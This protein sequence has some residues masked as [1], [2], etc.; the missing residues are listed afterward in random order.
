MHCRPFRT[1]L[2]VL[3]LGLAVTLSAVAQRAPS[4]RASRTV[5]DVLQALR[6]TGAD[7]LYSSDLV[8]ADLAA[9]PPHGDATP[10]QQAREALAAHGLALRE[11]SPDR[12][13]VTRGNGP[14][15]TAAE[16]PA[17]GDP[18]LVEDAPLTSVSVYASR[19]AIEGRTVGEPRL[20]APTDLEMVPGSQ[21]DALRALRAVPGLATSV[22]ARP[23]IRGSL[24]EDALIRFDGVTLLDPFHLK[25]FQSLISAI[26][27]AAVDR[28]EIYSSGFPVRY[29]TRSGGVIDITPRSRSLGYENSVS[30]SLL[31]A[32][33]ASVGRSERWPLEWLA[34]ARRS[35][36]DLVLEPLGADVGRPEFVDT[37]GRLRWSPNDRSAWTI[38]WLLLDDRIQ[39]KAEQEQASASY[40]DEYLWLGYEH[41]WNE[42]WRSRTVLASTTADR[43]RSGMLER[44][45]VATGTLAERRAIERRQLDSD[46]HWQ[47]SERTAVDYGATIAT[48]RANYDYQRRN[49]FA[50]AA[51]R[52]FE[53]RAIENFAAGARAESTSYAAYASIGHRWSRIEAEAGLRFDADDYAPGESFSHVSPRL[54]LRFDLSH[55]W[56]A[57]ASL[58]EFTQAQRVDEWRA[59][60][61]QRSADLP[62]V[63]VHSVLGLAYGVPDAANGSLEFYTK[64]WT[65]ASSYYDNLLNPLGLS[66]DL[67]PD[68]VRISPGASEASGV[69]LNLHV[70]LTDSVTVWTSIAAATVKDE[71]VDQEIVRS[72]D[73]PLAIVAGLAWSGSRVNVSL[74]GGWHRGWPRTPIVESNTV[75]ASAPAYVVGARNSERWRD[76]QTLDLRA[77][78]R[79]SLASGELQTFIELTNLANRENECCIDLDPPDEVGQLPLIETSHSLPLVI[80]LGA[81]FRWRSD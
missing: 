54:N 49:Q 15:P 25:N 43:S 9:P 26:D 6:A 28:L 55:A 37:L 34:T 57:Y 47:V 4:E 40:R 62:Q 38:G 33:V 53:R 70:P 72:W 10:L 60:E 42:R 50:A 39:L 41:R 21:D 58:G 76:F 13:V 80:N 12:Y 3:F 52:S 65:R 29:G 23:Y 48:A 30:L 17:S 44:P 1:N 46:W 36:V 74:L 73:Q 16:P 27:P 22:S 51:T 71:F 78:W 24:S 77:S 19:Y 35:T 18:R 14:V 68:R 32:G 11:I 7:V 45:W 8:R 61:A 64:R 2:G 56:H 67:A 31:T 81:T 66:P 59:E 69:E 20:L 79:R 5:D 75:P 63:A